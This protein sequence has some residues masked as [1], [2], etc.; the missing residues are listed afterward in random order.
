MNN[1]SIKARANEL[2]AYCKPQYIRIL[3]IMALVSMI[4]DT[5]SS[6]GVTAILYTIAM[7]A[8]IPFSHGYVVTS[9]KIVRNNYLDLNDSDA[10]VG[11][12][13]FKELFFTYFLYSLVVFGV[14]FVLVAVLFIVLVALGVALQSLTTAAMLIL[15][16]SVLTTVVSMLVGLYGFAFPYL[17][18]KY[19]YKG[20]AAIKESFK[21]IEGHLL[22]LFKLE[23]SYLGWTI[24]VAVVRM[25]LAEVL[26]FLGSTGVALASIAASAIAI[27]TYLPQYH[28]ARAIFFEEIAY[29]RYGMDTSYANSEEVVYEDVVEDTKQIE[30]LGDQDVQ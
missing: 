12:K 25:V 21:F 5:L 3:C 16:M 6:T 13:R 14:L 30:E 18:E 2:L 9:L 19:G 17:L 20:M 11:L 24:L 1:R 28:V 7:I 29:Q 8:L 4:P 27:F 23:L 22:D 26:K 10:F 15:V